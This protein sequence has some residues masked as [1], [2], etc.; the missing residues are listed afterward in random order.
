M[1]RGESKVLSEGAEERKVG[2]C[3]VSTSIIDEVGVGG[4]RFRP[5]LI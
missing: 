4:G 2:F 1:F 5:L 3:V